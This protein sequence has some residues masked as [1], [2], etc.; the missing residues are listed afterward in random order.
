MEELRDWQGSQAW[1][2]QVNVNYYAF[3]V[4]G[5]L[6]FHINQNPSAPE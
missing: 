5:A 2:P 6:L 4:L 3:L 1:H